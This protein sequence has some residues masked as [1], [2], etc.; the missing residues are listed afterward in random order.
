VLADVLRRAGIETLVI[1]DGY[2][3]PAVRAAAAAMDFPEAALVRY[4]HEP[5]A[6]DTPASGETTAQ[7]RARFIAR[8]RRI[9]LTH[10]VAIERVGPAHTVE[11]LRQQARGGPPPADSFAAQ[12][13]ETSADR[14]HNMRGEPIDEFAG[15]LHLLFE[16]LP[17]A[18]PEVRTIGVGDGANEIGMGVIPWEDL[19]RRLSGE[20]AGRVPCRVPCDFTIV[21][22]VSN[23]G[24]YALAAGFAYRRELRQLLEPHTAASQHR[25]LRAMVERGP[26]VDGVTR[27]QTATVDGLSFDEYIAPW[28]D[29]RRAL[30]LVE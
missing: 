2:C 3:F 14:C 11:S 16:E 6:C 15:D 26:A 13:A 30:D 18:L 19:S 4:P 21:A 7:W 12:V 1:T 27:Q 24:G 23:W 10:L 17:L 22:G 5:A 25:V 8:C 29:I 28:L 20:Q 9:G